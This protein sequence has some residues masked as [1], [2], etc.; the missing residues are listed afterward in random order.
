MAIESTCSGCGK[1]LAVADQYVGR[2]ARCPSCGNIYTVPNPTP[3]A[4]AGGQEPPVDLAETTAAGHGDTGNAS[5]Q[6]T[7]SSQFWMRTSEG[8]EYGPVTRIDLN[9]WFEEG[10]VGDNYTIRQ[11]DEGTWQSADRFRPQA[12]ANPYA[13]SPPLPHQAYAQSSPASQYSKPDQS[14]IILAM[15]ILGFFICP[16]FG[17]IAWIMGNSA[18]ADIRAGLVD[19]SGKEM[20]RVGYYLGIANVALTVTSISAFIVVFALALVAG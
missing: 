12:Q 2:Q 16:V 4:R 19:P 6:S 13:S 9:R 15:G 7:L 1:K 11:G 20:I 8:S 14:G 17:V 10:R 3:A 5:S 18:L